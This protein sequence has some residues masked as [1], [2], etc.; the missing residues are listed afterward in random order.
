MRHEVNIGVLALPCN[1]C[2]FLRYELG[3]S[4]DHDSGKRGR[5]IHK[6]EEVRVNARV[7][8]R[9]LAHFLNIFIQ[10]VCNG[11]ELIHAA[12]VAN[13]KEVDKLINW[14]NAFI[15]AF[16]RVVNVI[17]SVGIWVHSVLLLLRC[18]VNILKHT[19]AVY[20][21]FVLAGYA[22]CSNVDYGEVDYGHEYQL[23]QIGY[24][25]KILFTRFLINLDHYL[26]F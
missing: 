4:L 5:L 10:A 20:D 9:I 8:L 1:L 11:L 12:F 2:N 13:D 6:V 19:S 7:P 17:N 18:Y 25:E 21:A 16:A 14:F 3:L 22:L 24:P 15:I 26:S 23:D